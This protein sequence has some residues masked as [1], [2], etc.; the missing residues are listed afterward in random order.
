MYAVMSRFQYSAQLNDML[1]LPPWQRMLQGDT[2]LPV[3]LLFATSFTIAEAQRSKNTSSL[4][5][6]P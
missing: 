3:K 5:R 2:K 4:P 6:L 1:N